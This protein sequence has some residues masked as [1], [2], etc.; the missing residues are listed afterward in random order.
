VASYPTN[1]GQE[2]SIE[3]HSR[4]GTTIQHQQEPPQD[5]NDDIN[6]KEAPMQRRPSELVQDQ[7]NATK[8]LPTTMN[9]PNMEEMEEWLD[10]L[11]E[12]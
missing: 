10:D 12:Q 11:L 7:L 3:E 8:Q 6:H 5:T 4:L 9:K 1:D 2:S